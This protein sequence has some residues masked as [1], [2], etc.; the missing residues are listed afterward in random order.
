MSRDLAKLHFIVVLWG[1]TAVL[2]RFLEGLPSPVLV[3]HRTLIAGLLLVGLVLYRKTPGAALRA[4]VLPLFG[5]G[6]LLGAHWI[7]F[8]LAVHLGNVSVC[9]IG[10]ATSTLWTAI[11][12]PM[13]VR[14]RRHHLYEFALGGVMIGAI[15][16]I[17]GGDFQYQ[18]GLAVG[19]AAAGVGT[20]F[21]IINSHL[22]RRHHHNVIALYQMVGAMSIC[23]AATV[24]M[25]AFPG[26]LGGGGAPLRVLP[27]P[28]EFGWL[29]LLASFC[30][31]YSYA[32]YIELL[33][34]LTVFTVHLS[35]NLEPVYG[36]I[37]AAIIFKE[38]QDLSS[39]FYLGAAII[40]AAVVIHPFVERLYRRRRRQEQPT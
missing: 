12:E 30:T 31:V 3:F 37:L 6:L 28:A 18:L 4:E 36:I 39:T 20:T 14:G 19:I 26:F 40:V 33:K 34:R 22:T 11:L 32:Q 15:A 25:A 35:Y 7:L 10:M 2:G 8:F 23:A 9:M 38:H 16:L 1:F 21:S 24:A 17:A 5:N 27:S 29:F 13:M